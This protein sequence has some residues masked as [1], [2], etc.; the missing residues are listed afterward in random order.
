MP[1][2]SLWLRAYVGVARGTVAV[3][4]HVEKLKQFR[5]THH[6]SGPHTVSGGV[7]GARCGGDMLPV[8]PWSYG[9]LTL[10]ADALLRCGR[11]RSQRDS[12]SSEQLCS[13]KSIL[14][15]PILYAGNVVRVMHGQAIALT[16]SCPKN[17]DVPK[18]PLLRKVAD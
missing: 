18:S 13:L 15:G 9:R 12:E 2:V 14:I 8:I 7:C 4:Y 16:E 17:G 1:E 5:V 3:C 6:M 10:I 11:R